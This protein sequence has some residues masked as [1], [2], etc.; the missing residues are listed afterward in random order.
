MNKQ[1]AQSSPAELLVFPT[2][3]VIYKWANMQHLAILRR[4][5]VLNV[6]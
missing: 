5:V 2:K 3:C 1:R 6:K 4:K